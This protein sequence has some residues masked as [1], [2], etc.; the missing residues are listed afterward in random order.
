[1]VEVRRRVRKGVLRHNGLFKASYDQHHGRNNR[2]A[3]SL[4]GIWPSLA[5]PGLRQ[6]CS[7]A[8]QQTKA[9]LTGLC[10]SICP[11]TFSGLTTTIGGLETFPCGL[12]YCAILF[13]GGVVTAPCCE[14]WL[15]L[16]PDPVSDDKKPEA[17]DDAD[18]CPAFEP[19][20]LVLA[21]PPCM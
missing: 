13:E 21:C 7:Q 10:C 5:L 18:D 3:C 4:S 19:L 11:L 14:L 6:R 1:M 16:L 17:R 15:L 12:S 2:A 20:P 8:E 9:R